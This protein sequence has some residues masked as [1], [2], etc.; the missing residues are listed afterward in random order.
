MLSCDMAVAVIRHIAHAPR[1]LVPTLA[2]VVVVLP[3]VR[4][5]PAD[6][7]CPLFSCLGGG[8][9]DSDSG[10]EDE[11]KHSYGPC[12]CQPR[13]TLMQWSYGTSFSGGPP[14][15][16]EPLDSDR[17]GF[18]E[19]T[20]TV[21]RGVVQLESGYTF[22]LDNH[23]GDHQ[24]SHAFPD[25]LWRIGM[26]AEWFEWRIEYNYEIIND[27]IS[28][29][30]APPLHRHISGSDDLLLG[31]KL[32]LTPQEGI[33]PAMILNP[34]MSVP[35]GSPSLTQGEVMPGVNWGYSWQITK[36]L[37]LSGITEIHRASDD[38]GN[39]FAEFAQAFNLEIDFTK[40][41][42]GYIEWFVI[43]PVS[44]TVHTQHNA[45]GGF[46]FRINN[47]LQL[48]IECGVGLNEPAPDFFAAAGGTVR[49]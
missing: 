17:P 34:E 46:I 13:K 4:T 30:G 41:F 47:N 37:S 14:G 39:V 11:P 7:A 18:T 40:K 1:C 43:S 44:G 28:A 45:D 16:D 15:M 3:S 10:K 32:D 2:L 9:C 36:K 5:A 33:L 12:D 22:T 31:I 21:G 20:T 29:G 38:A 48:D 25:T 27:T 8:N 42:A 19:A 6:D 24:T 26:F 23:L 49:F 35:S